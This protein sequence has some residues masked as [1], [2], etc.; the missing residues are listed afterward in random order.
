MNLGAVTRS[1]GCMAPAFLTLIS[2]LKAKI[3]AASI[4]PCAS[5]QGLLLQRAAKAGVGWAP[6]QHPPQRVKSF[7]CP[8]TAGYLP[9]DRFLKLYLV[10]KNSDKK[11]PNA[12]IYHKDSPFSHT[13]T[14]TRKHTHRA[15]ITETF[16]PL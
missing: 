9:L 1:A 6:P 10:L 5:G 2:I 14:H 16:Y 15:A 12:R 7:T 4:I 8:A 13:C 3:A 11:N